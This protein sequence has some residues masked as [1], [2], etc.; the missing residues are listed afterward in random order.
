ML[1]AAGD[2]HSTKDLSG[3][4]DW[5]PIVLPFTTKPDQTSATV[6]LQFG[7]PSSLASGHAYF[8]KVTL[9]KVGYPLG[10]ANL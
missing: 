2:S 6:R 8:R 5:T 3:S 7:G 9:Q 1:L 10:A 4:A